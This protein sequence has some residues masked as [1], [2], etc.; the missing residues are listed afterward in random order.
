[1]KIGLALSNDW[2]LF[3]DGSGDYYNIQHKPLQELL[4][5]AKSY[6]ARISVMAEYCQQQAFKELGKDQQKWAGD[7]A[8]S[9]EQILINTIQQGHDVQ[10]HIHP[11][12][13]NARYKQDKWILDYSKW[14]FS[15]LNT[16]EMIEVLT[17]G[18]HYL[19]TLLGPADKNYECIIFRAGAYCI[20]PSKQAIESLLA[21]GFKGDTSVTRGMTDPVF[22]NYDQAYSNVVPW[23]CSEDVR[24][25][26]DNQGKALVEIP[27]CSYQARDYPVIRRLVSRR[28][29]CF[30]SFGIWED[31]HD[32]AWHYANEQYINKIYPN[33]AMKNKQGSKQ[34]LILWRSKLIKSRYFQLDYDNL[35]PKTFVRIIQQIVESLE[36]KEWLK[37]HEFIPVLASGHTK[38]MHSVDNIERILYELNRAFREHLSYIKIRDI[39]TMV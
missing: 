11:Q 37:T 32:L 26:S 4:T 15:S 2:E 12:W 27:I 25:Y 30:L 16:G 1:M 7:I 36:A 33:P 18:K 13:L 3:G 24:Y 17:K 9:W 38:T 14:A 39:C 10:L 22:Y 21:C 6:D 28:L 19:E 29:A 31:K 35:S 20:Q 8:N 5:A 23:L 34:K